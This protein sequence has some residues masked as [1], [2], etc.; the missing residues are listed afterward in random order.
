MAREHDTGRKLDQKDHLNDQMNRLAQDLRNTGVNPRR[1]LWGDIDQAISQAEANQIKTGSSRRWDWPQLA[2]IA[3][4]IT[5]FA[6]AVW[7][8]PGFEF[9]GG[10]PLEVV[11]ELAAVAP[12]ASGL[13]V[14]DQA[15]SELNLALAEDPDNLSLSNLALM[16]HQSRGRILRQNADP[17]LG[18][19]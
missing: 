19:G 9:R 15:L 16:L 13:E 2:A 14:I 10:G 6:F 12:E 7:W 11:A 18:G 3:A 4:M 5:F 8:G 1:D 17:R